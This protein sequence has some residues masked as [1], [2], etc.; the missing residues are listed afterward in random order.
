MDQICNMDQI[1]NSETEGPYEVLVMSDASKTDET[2]M[3]VAW[4]ISVIRKDNEHGHNSWGW[5]DNE[6]KLMV[7]D[8]SCEDEFSVEELLNMK[9]DR[10][11]EALAICERRNQ[12]AKQ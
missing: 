3:N 9:A 7:D 8:F 4:E 1:Y 5:G 11:E 6:T 10:I 12:R 2:G